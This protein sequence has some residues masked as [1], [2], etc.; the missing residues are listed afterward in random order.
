MNQASVMTLSPQSDQDLVAAARDGDERA[1]EELYERYRRKINAFALRLTRDPDRADDITQEVFISALRRLRENDRPIT[2]RP[3]IYEI[4]RNACIDEYRRGRRNPEIPIERDGVDGWLGA[5]A[6]SPPPE[7]VVESKQQ[8]DHLCGAFRGLSDRHHKIIVLRELEGLTYSQIGDQLGMSKM[9]VES[10]LFRARRRLTEEFDDLSSGRRCEYVRA[11]LDSRCDRPSR[12]LGLRDRRALA[13]HIEHCRPCRREA[14]AAG[15]C[16]QLD[17]HR[18]VQKVAALAPVPLLALVRRLGGRAGVLVRGAHHASLPFTSSAASFAAPIAS[19]ASA[20]RVA[21]AAATLLLAAVGGGVIGEVAGAGARAGGR[22]AIGAP[23]IVQRAGSVAGRGAGLSQAVGSGVLARAGRAHVVA[24]VAPG[25]RRG[26][27]SRAG[28]RAG[29]LG[30]GSPVAAG[31]RAIGAGR[32][33]P[34]PGSHAG[35]GTNLGSLGSVGATGSHG[36]GGLGSGLGSEGI[37]VGGPSGP[38]SV[39]GSVGSG[40]PAAPDVPSAPPAS[41]PSL[42][43]LPDPGMVPNS[44]LR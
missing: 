19:A 23:P 24:G 32:N 42:P 14:L 6:T 28:R 35:G 4:A 5:L 16:V 18:Q 37:P 20:G 25:D 26:S 39:P 8:L 3:W 10:T 33:R 13:H 2:F 31:D 17:K 36:S 44:G 12:Q 15:I 9:V 27:S 40:A 43:P 34:S 7:V 41:A 29:G 21:A 11:M 22:G 1:F 38:P 30:A